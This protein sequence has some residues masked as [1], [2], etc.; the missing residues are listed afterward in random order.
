MLITTVSF[1]HYCESSNLTKFQCAILRT[2]QDDIELIAPTK[3][4]PT[5]ICRRAL[6]QD[7]PV[8]IAHQANFERLLFQILIAELGLVIVGSQVGR[9][10]LISLTRPDDAFSHHGPVTMFRVDHILPSYTHEI[11]G[12]RPPVPLLGVAVSPLQGQRDR[13]RWRLIMQYYDHSIL[14]YELSREGG[15]LLVL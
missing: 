14:T 12:F 11:R 6:H 4:I 8:A 5:I 15:E 13:K 7:L 2:Y 10:A 1:F 9:V 3:T